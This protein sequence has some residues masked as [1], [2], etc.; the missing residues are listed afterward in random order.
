M[1]SQKTGKAVDRKDAAIYLLREYGISERRVC[2]V[3]RIY[4]NMY[5]YK[6]KKDTQAYL[7]M[8]IREIAEARVRFGYR[9]IHVLLQK[10]GFK[11]NHKRVYRLY[12]EEG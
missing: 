3:L 9:R 6:S 2:A 12:C 11:I 1:C 8:R 10:E 4:R 5:R 7:R